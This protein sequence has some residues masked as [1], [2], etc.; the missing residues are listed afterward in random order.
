[1][2]S[3]I[4]K[5]LTYLFTILVIGFTPLDAIEV[6]EGSGITL[7]RYFFIAMAGC[8]ILS[9]DLAIKKT[10][11]LLK[12]LLLFVLWAFTTVLWSIDTEITLIRV[13]YL[14]QYTIIF[15]VMV[16]TLREPKMIKVAMAAWIIGSCFIAY[17]SITDFNI[18]AGSSSSIA[19]RVNS[20]GN[21]NEN[22]FML[23]YALVF[24]YL[25]DR[26]RLRIPSLAL[27]A[28]AVYALV[29]NG[30]RMGII[31]FVLSVT[32]F[33]IQL[34]QSKKRWYMIILIPGILAFGIYVLQHIPSASLMR[35]MGITESIEEGNFSSRES[36][37]ESAWNML[38]YNP[39]YFMIGCGWGTFSIVITR[40]LGYTIGAHNFYLDLLCTTGIIGLSIVLYY[41]WKLFKL[42]RHTPKATIVNY[43]LLVIPLISMLS[44]NWQS[45]RWWFMM[46]AFIYLVYRSKN[47]DDA[48]EVICRK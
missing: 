1:M 17:K 39:Y 24:C 48:K 30:S 43:L 3:N 22:S 26:T 31:L 13:L 11:G 25:I 38:N 40:Y 8:A 37:W 41:F 36:I 12:V 45:R 23:C 21:P 20:F 34:W 32:G 27:T 42:I 7:G 46:G 14:I 44:T 2:S 47:L 6:S 19:Y 5:K 18:F 4:F 28:Y 29:A 16:N 10:G 15:L 33:C 9:G 35:I